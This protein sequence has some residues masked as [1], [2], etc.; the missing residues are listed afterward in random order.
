MAVFLGLG[1]WCRG[2]LLLGVRLRSVLFGWVVLLAG[3]DLAC[4]R[5]RLTFDC[6][7]RGF[8]R[9]CWLRQGAQLRAWQLAEP[10]V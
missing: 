4:R 8:G 6:L 2:L 9:W 3:S 7:G 1:L 10:L 5:L